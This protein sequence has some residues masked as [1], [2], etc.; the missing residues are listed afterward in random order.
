MQKQRSVT[1]TQV[2][3]EGFVSFV[4]ITC[5]FIAYFIELL[6]YTSKLN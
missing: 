5:K 2:A 3:Y 4:W 6:R 1:Y